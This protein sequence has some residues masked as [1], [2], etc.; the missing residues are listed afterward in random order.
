MVKETILQPGWKDVNL[1]SKYP[2][3]RDK[4]RS[5]ANLYRWVLLHN[6]SV[7]CG[8]EF[9]GLDDTLCEKV[10]QFSI[11]F[12]AIKFHWIPSCSCVMS[13]ITWGSQIYL[14]YSIHYFVNL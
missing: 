5:E 4:F 6:Q 13:K 1:F 11:K 3:T 14:L 7:S 12:V 10:S 9:H 8:H 2:Q